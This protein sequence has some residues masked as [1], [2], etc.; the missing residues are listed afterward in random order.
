MLKSS[1]YDHSDAYIFI[2]GTI[3]VNNTTDAD[4]DADN[5]NIK[6]IFKN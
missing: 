5:T 3:T 1:L 4:A 6:V 2:E